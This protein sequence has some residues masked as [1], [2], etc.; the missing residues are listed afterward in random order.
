MVLLKISNL[1]YLFPFWLVCPSEVNPLDLEILKSSLVMSLFIR[2]LKSPKIT[3]L[4][5]SL[6]NKL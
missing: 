6:L 2:L 1:K 4:F 3:F 5:P